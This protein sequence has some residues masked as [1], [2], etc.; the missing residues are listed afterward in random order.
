MTMVYQVVWSEKSK[1]DLT[2]IIE[3]L[4]ENWGVAYNFQLG[5]KN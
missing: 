3:Y 4:V 1:T 5:I 2:E